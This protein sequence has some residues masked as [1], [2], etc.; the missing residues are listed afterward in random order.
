VGR[1]KVSFVLIVLFIGNIINAQEFVVQYQQVINLGEPEIAHYELYITKDQSLYFDVTQKNAAALKETQEH[2]FTTITISEERQPN[3]IYIDFSIR[4]LYESTY[5]GKNNVVIE[6]NLY[7]FDWNIT[8]ET[9]QIADYI[10]TKATT[11]FRGRDYEVWFTEEIATQA[12]PWKMHGLPGLILELY[13]TEHLIVIHAKKISTQ[14]LGKE[15]A[16]LINK[17][18]KTK[19]IS[20]REYDKLFKKHAQELINQMMTKMPEGFPPMKIDENCED[21]QSLEIY[22]EWEK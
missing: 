22:E 11:R 8:G 7:P 18:Q 1:I 14:S 13:D 4:A 19:T 3:N 21:C 20:F 15:Q 5:L 17:I 16:G 10:C 6:E 2:N 9:K 12:G